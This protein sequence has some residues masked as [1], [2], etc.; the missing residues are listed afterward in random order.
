[1]RIQNADGIWEEDVVRV[2]EI[3]LEGFAKLYR[4]KLISSPIIPANIFV[5]GNCLFESEAINLSL[6]PT[7]AKI[8]FALNSMKA[9]KAPSPNGL[10]AGFF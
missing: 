1:M 9:F 2:K 7:D 10:H 3:F 5:W 8:L 4:T 6:A